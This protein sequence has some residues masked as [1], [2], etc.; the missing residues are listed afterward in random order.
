[1]ADG[2]PAFASNDP[3]SWP[4]QARYAMQGRWD[5]IDKEYGADGVRISGGSGGDSSSG[6]TSG[7][8]ASSGMAAGAAAAGAAAV[9]ASGRTGSGAS[10]SSAKGDDLTTIVGIGPKAAE[11]LKAD[12]IVSYRDLANSDQPRLRGI[13]ERGGSRFSL[14]D[15]TTW[16]EQA[17]LAS[18]GEWDKLSA[19]QSEM[20]DTAFA[21]KSLGAG[22]VAAATPAAASPRAAA[23]GKSDDLTKVEGIGPKIAQVLRDSGIN[24]F[25]ELSRAEIPTLKGILEKA[26]PR[27]V[28][29]DP[30]TWPEQARYAADGQWDQLS[31]FQDELDGGRRVS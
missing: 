13:I 15:S 14:L 29:A 20:S 3:S 4:E 23:G 10:G 9:G 12:G 18:D 28:L 27:F 21:S 11:L 17:R 19:M 1:M 6:T 26:G 8:S 7:G 16:P 25:S 24:S 5:V 31:K 22:S 2:G 30:D